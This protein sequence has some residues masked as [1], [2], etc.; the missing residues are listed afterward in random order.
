MKIL[1]TGGAGFIASHVADAYIE[2]GHDV[3]IVDD[4]SNGS[5]DN[6]NPKARFHRLD[7]VDAD[8]VQKVFE[9]EKP[10]FVSHHAAKADIALINRD[11]MACFRTN[12]EGTWNILEAAASVG[13]RKF[14]MISTS[15]TYGV[16]N[17]NPV[18][19]RHPPQPSTPYGTS[20]VVDERLV[21]FVTK[22]S[23]MDWTILRYGNV[24]GPRQPIKGEAG[25]IGI[26]ARAMLKKET[27]YITGDGEQIKDYVYV[28]DVVALNVALLDGGSKGVYN[29][30]TGVGT[31]VN[32]IFDML[33]KKIGFAGRPRYVAAR[34]GDCSFVFDAGRA[35]RELGWAPR[36]SLAEGMDL[37]IAY[38]R[39]RC[40]V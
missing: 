40:R 37:T 2:A 20:K 10:E 27:P 25:V 28:S 32:A 9:A 23:G 4:L 1:I 8:A 12:I 34:E 15:A 36:V 16:P 22:T 35:G 29:A 3:A 19:E 26:F 38:E 21:H 39:V 17:Y 30:G 7:I 31:S 24:Y 13:A 11:P 33:A 14:V 18:D 6:V 5:M